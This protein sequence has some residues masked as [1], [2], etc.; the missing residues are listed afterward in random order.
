MFRTLIHHDECVD[1]TVVAV[2][3]L[4]VAGEA[5][6]VAPV[7]ECDV[8]QQD[9]DVIPPGRAHE[10]YTLVIHA[11]HRLHVLLGDHRLAQ[12]HT[13]TH[14][15]FKDQGSNDLTMGSLN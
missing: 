12:L 4:G 10:L 5:D 11:H 8:P 15:Q 7:L 6:V 1:G 2:L 9:R 14:T 3:L 13:H